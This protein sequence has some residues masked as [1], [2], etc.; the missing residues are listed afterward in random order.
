[1]KP[2]RFGAAAI[3]AVAVA[4]ASVG[5]ISAAP[6]AGTVAD[7]KAPSFK[8]RVGAVLSF[9]GPLAGFGP[10]LDA[11]AR[12]AVDEI[13]AALRR[14]GLSRQMSAQ[15]VGTED[16]QG[17][18][19]PGVEAA[20]KLVQIQKANVLVGTILSSTTIAVAQSV[21]IPNNV[22]QIAPT[23]SSPAIAD[24]ADRNLVWRVST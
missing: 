13:N 4:L 3:L 23:S 12:M 2:R 15:W 1:M 14:R 6:A 21:T 10:S 22:V 17:Q 16:D 9:S 19:Q 11:S 20:T 8:L 18:I 24:L 5:V 7:K